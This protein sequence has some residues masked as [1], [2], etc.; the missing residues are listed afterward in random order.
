[1][2]TN[3]K[4]PA[5]MKKK[6][7]H[8]GRLGEVSDLLKDLNLNTVCRSARCP[9]VNECY[10][11]GTATF[12]IMGNVCTRD[13]RFC[14][15]ATGCPQALDPEEPKR[16]ADAIQKL[17]LRHAVITSVTRDDLP[18]GGA[19]HFAEV[20][21]AIQ[22]VSNAAIEVLTPDFQGDRNS[23]A[24]VLAASPDIFNHNVETVPR[25]YSAIRPQ[26]HY[27]RSLDVLKMAKEIAPKVETKSGLMVGL[28]ERFEEVVETLRDMRAVHCDLVTIGQYLAPT[29]KHAPLVEFVTP[30]TFAKYESVGR[31]MGFA[32]VFAGPFVR[33]S[34]LAERLHNQASREES[35]PKTNC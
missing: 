25:L 35:L 29:D 15:V 14:A 3:K 33:S 5:W 4:F 13:C 19:A 21:S 11:R 26:A 28:G 17:K 7:C 20:I 24:T 27:R 23:I 30:E 10:N 12:M 16:V 34:Y 22:A 6:V 8:D 1:M 2:S 31:E 9:N 18:D 32:G